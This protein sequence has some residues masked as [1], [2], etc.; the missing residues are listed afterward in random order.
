MGEDL[1]RLGVKGWWVVARDR[2]SWRKIK[3]RLELIC[4]A[5]YN[6]DNNTVQYMKATSSLQ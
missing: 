6:D 4:S 2:G 3:P 1:G 5:E